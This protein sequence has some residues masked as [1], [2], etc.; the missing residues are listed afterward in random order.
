MTN[1]EISVICSVQITSGI[2]ALGMFMVR[3]STRPVEE[4]VFDSQLLRAAL[5]LWL[6]QYGL[7]IVSALQ[8]CQCQVQVTPKAWM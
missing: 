8:G 1:T 7:G 4:L 5:A 3:S 6:V 2:Q